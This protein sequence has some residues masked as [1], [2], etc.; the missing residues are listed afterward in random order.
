MLDQEHILQTMYRHLRTLLVRS[1]VLEHTAMPRMLD[2]IA[3]RI[4]LHILVQELTQVLTL[5]REHILVV[6]QTRMLAQEPIRAAILV[7]EH[8]R[9]LT[10]AHMLA[11][12]FKQLK[13]P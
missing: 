10:L 11:T 13:I 7:Q 4:H 8:I 3:A 9:V 2:H 6:M 12:L 1:Q 5:V